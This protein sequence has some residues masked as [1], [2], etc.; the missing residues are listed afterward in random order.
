MGTPKL[1]DVFK[2]RERESGCCLI[3]GLSR[4]PKDDKRGAILFDLDYAFCSKE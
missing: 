1:I 4:Q 3:E 2:E